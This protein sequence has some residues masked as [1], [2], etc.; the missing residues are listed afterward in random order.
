MK[1]T[2][3]LAVLLGSV[4]VASA[5][6]AQSFARRRVPQ[7]EVT[8]LEM[9]I[10]GT[11]RAIPG[12][13]LRWEL[14][15]YEVVRRTELRPSPGSLVRVTASSDP[16]SPLAEVTTDAAGRASLELPIGDELERSPHLMLEAISSRGIR[17][18]FEVDLE[19][20]PRYQA[21]LLVD[22]DVVP[23]GGSVMVFGRVLDRALGRAASALDVVV[24][25]RGAS[26]PVGPPIELQTDAAGVFSTRVV[27]PETGEVRLTAGGVGFS[28]TSPVRVQ[29]PVRGALHVEAVPR[30][31]LAS[32]GDTVTVDLLVRTAEGAPVPG[33]QLGWEEQE[34]L[35]VD[36]RLGARTDADGRAT[37]DYPMP[38]RLEAPYLTHAWT[39][40]GV[41]PAHGSARA[42]VPVRVARQRVFA[43][44]AVAGGA[45]TPELEGRVL[46]RVVGADG[47]PLA[48][49]ALTLT[50]PR[51]GGGLGGRTDA[52]GVVV[53]RARVGPADP[54]EPCGGPT[55][56][57]A[58]LAVEGH[59]ESLCLPVDP[60]ATL[61][62]DAR[63]Q[64]DGHRLRVELA[65]RASV[66]RAPIV[67]TALV[68]RGEGWAPLAQ[69]S[70][71]PGASS[72][73]LPLPATVFGEVWVRAR[74]VLDGREVRGGGAMV[75]VGP[76]PGGLTL[77]VD[78]E[79][80]R[81][82]GAQP[83]DTVAVL[84]VDPE[85][86]DALLA[87]LHGELGPV[88]GALDA[89]SGPVLAELLLAARAPTDEAVSAVLRDGAIF[90]L[91]LP[92]SPASEGLLRDPWRTRARFVR[93]RVGRLLRAVESYVAVRVPGETG[94]TIEDV[95]VLDGGR[96]RFNADLLEGVLSETDLGAEGATSLDGEP[97]DIAGL[98]AL[99][100]SFSYDNVARRITRERHWSL[101]LRLRRLVHQRELD[102]AWARQGD[103]SQYLLAMLDAD[104]VEWELEPPSREALTDA[105]GTPFALRPVRGAARFTF[106]QPV[107]GHELVSA[108]PDRRFGTADDLVS[109]F[110]RVLPSGGL[111]AE[112]VGED[113][114]LAELAGVALGRAT[115]ESLG[116]LFG[117][118]APA[119]GEDDPARAAA[120]SVPP[121]VRAAS[122]GPVP[123]PPPLAAIADVGRAAERPWTLPSERRR[124]AAV[125]LRFRPEGPPSSARAGLVAGAPY[126]L[127]VELP[128]MLRPGEELSVPFSVVPLAEASPPVI[129]VES[130]SVALEARVEGTRLRLVA[131]RP[132][133]ARVVLTVR[134][135]ERV[136]ASREATVRVVP[137]APLRA[138][139]VSAW[140]S[141]RATLSAPTPAGARPW[142]AR[143]VVTAP[144]ALDADPRLAPLREDHPALFAW[145][146]ALR[147]DRLDPALVARVAR[148]GGASSAPIEVACGLMALTGTD[149]HGLIGAAT[150]ALGARLGDGLEERAA[151]LAALAP[152][153]PGHWVQGGDAVERLAGELREDGWRA[154]V[155]A[156]DRPSVMA[157]MAAALLLVD[158]ED[159]RGLALLA[160][161]RAALEL[162]GSGRR[163]VAGQ[164]ERAGDGW[165]GTLA[166]AI[167]ARQAGEDGLAD[168]L[169][170]SA[171]S[172]L[173]LV[174][175]V[176]VEGAFWALAASVYGA[177]G[178]DGPERV[179]VRVDGREATLE[180]SEGSA[181]LALPPTARADLSGAAGALARV[182]ARFVSDAAGEGGP[183]RAWVEGDP[184]RFGERSGLELVVE[185]EGEVGAPVVELALPGAARL[186][187][188]ALAVLRRT[189][190]VQRVSPPDGAGVL[191]LHLAPLAAGAT[192]RVALPWR[193]VAAGR[194]LG[195]A[196][197]SYDAS[198]PS[199]MSLAP[200]RML[201]L[202][203]GR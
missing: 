35:P 147:G 144:R 56:A 45:L 135:D 44:W 128:E 17:R 158:R 164:A 160:R 13:R 182:E 109:P 49:R 42:S 151:V 9:G 97:L 103:P 101:L 195:L 27:L 150:R 124:Y 90:T 3:T 23:P 172:R 93:G 96:L 60:D 163:W 141:E 53:L 197:T 98:T 86:A 153:A 133:R 186:D 21:Q 146:Q 22:R 87:L 80:A 51:L 132:G 140:V 202:E 190:A 19:L 111:Y 39:V 180:L 24:R 73:E 40:R 105:W 145:A 66:T 33:A 50:V 20:E 156:T 29:A 169:A 92:S 131:R 88:A 31:A 77:E 117:V 116:A 11:L 106:L 94:A 142:G 30:Q 200:G 191:R 134:V 166:L 59:R 130:G 7:G 138:R 72:V 107:P 79:R 95:A 199:R 196:L 5:A 198:A 184:G 187:A 78:A 37:L 114:L 165:I 64:A 148:D 6:S 63:P 203:E 176:G 192:H 38:R 175:R 74:P 194:T 18:V 61:A 115:V 173:V 8:G 162:D 55:A 89:G 83:E 174:P 149:E 84:A 46:V 4:L 43:T 122:P 100:P 161:A 183:L 2:W 155:T 41:H 104:D 127:G 70:A 185:G 118:E 179:V 143:L 193:W 120:P 12:E 139:H 14:T 188:A 152:V 52:D 178:V 129:E 189:A 110:A 36:E 126:A 121:P 26:G 157:R 67:V 112:A 85:R 125:A 102:V 69:T 25:A 159:A 1:T 108:G 171:A 81:V 58:E 57:S 16:S 82:G 15:L 154:L 113:A 177:F 123:L 167:A 170:A 62:L 47:A 48:G 34:R 201:D 136:V 75:W 71:A 99:D 28:A 181:E 168:E 32:P 68:R 54:D 137:S 119:S 65:R 10:Q 76:A 91:P